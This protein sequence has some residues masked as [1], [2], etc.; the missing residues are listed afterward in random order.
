MERWRLLDTGIRTA[1]ENIAFD[2]AILTAKGEGVTPNTVR[3]L[4]FNPEAVL[5]G[6]HQSVDQE[7]RTPFCRR[8]HIDINRRITGGGAIFF[9]KSQIG[10]EIIASKGDLKFTVPHEEVFQEM[11][12]PVI[13]GLKRL[14]IEARYRSKNDIEVKGRKISGTGGTE[15]K[16]AFLFQGT[17]LVDLD[18]ETMLRALRIPTEK[19]R[20]REIDSLGERLTCLRQEL[21]L[22][23]PVREVKEGL[24]RGFEE[25]FH[26]DLVVGGLNET[27]KNL[28]A[29]FLPKY[30]SD[31]WIHLIKNPPEGK[32]I[33]QG[34]HKSKG[35]L[36]RVFLAYDLKREMISNILITGDFFVFPQGAIYDLEAR[37]KDCRRHMVPDVVRKFFMEKDSYIPHVSPEDFSKAIGSAL[38]KADFAR[39]GLSFS[40]ANRIFTVNGRFR[41]ILEK[42]INLLLL[43]YCAK[44]PDCRFRHK[45][46]CAE[47]ERC[48][49]GYAYNLGRGYGLIPESIQSFEDLM[50][51]LLKYR[52]K[53]FQAFIG[54]CCEQFFIK[55]KGDFERIGMPGIL[56]NIDNETCYDL[57]K[58]RKAY[59]GD[60]ENLT[61]LKLD[62]LEKVIK[63]RGGHLREGD[64]AI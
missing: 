37:L 7:V 34:T 2:E 33:L 41:E 30:Q 46:G 23:P 26:I 36:I 50:R 42:D 55:H 27:E 63:A 43:P 38:E 17:L 18:L 10:W 59:S 13:Q 12:E 44:L 58:E 61:R 52:S 54:C 51:T 35:G 60:F 40:E 32:Q 57:G 16:G 19:L 1:A 21:G 8:H 64:R 49:V 31:E 5:V 4:Q 9:D 14:G 56:V 62:L 20:D 29:E 53:E 11:C 3:F 22:L 28:F 15:H 47:C 39:Y 48:D 45:K 24:K 6:Y 25:V